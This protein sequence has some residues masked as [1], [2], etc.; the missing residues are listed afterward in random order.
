MGPRPGVGMTPRS[1]AGMRALL[2]SIV[3]AAGG[4]GRLAARQQDTIP[5]PDTARAAAQD[6]VRLPPP[7]LVPW[8]ASAL[9]GWDR[10]TWT[11]NR[12][13]LAG[14]GAFS[15]LDLLRSVPGMATLQA[16]AFVQPEAAT[17]I[18]AGAGRTEI[19]IDGYIL[20]PLTAA[21]FDLSTVE[22]AA[23]D[24][25]R[26]ERRLD[27]TRIR[28]RTLAPE[29][30][31]TFS[32][33]EAGVGEPR[34]NMFRGLLLAPRVIV[35]PFGFAVERLEAQGTGP[36]R[37]ADTFATW[38]KWGWLAPNRGL[39]LEWRSL[40]L[41]REPESA[42]PIDGRRSD[43][44]LRGRNRFAD[45]LVGEAYAGWASE[46]LE[47]LDPAVPDSLR[48]TLEESSRQAG[49]RAALQR[50][51]GGVDAALRLR[52]H[53]AFA[54]WQADVSANVA[55][56][57]RADLSLRASTSGWRNDRRTTE[58]G[59]SASLVPVDAVR[60]FGEYS[61]G[62]SGAPFFRADS[63]R[64]GP[65]VSDR[66]AWRAGVE[67]RRFGI[68]A[69][70]AAL[71][72]ETDS[73]VTFGLPGDSAAPVLP[74]GSL[75]GWEAFARVP[76]RSDWLSA[77]FAY[78]TWSSGT[79]WAYVPGSSLSAALDLHAL[80]LE[81]G[82]LELIGRFQILQRGDVAAPP[83]VPGDPLVTL[84]SRTRFSGYF[85]IRIIDVR[86]FV[87]FEDIQ[88]GYLT[89]LP[90]LDIR[91]PRLVYGVKWNFWN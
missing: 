7:L 55:P 8:P 63:L 46:R 84:A 77:S 70:A 24:Q 71:H 9:D 37:P 69:G 85:Q 18:G 91:G 45:G 11:W 4:P 1:R 20:D 66:T 56:I 88:G 44:V 82:N 30:A 41:S 34:A 72:A 68:D 47:P 65:L 14:E 22:L 35:G 73:V 3:I 62:E 57:S 26:I 31:R 12:D 39:Q 6:T 2:A 89:D 16:G 23:L 53:P 58:F 76:L 49:V 48:P 83:P 81:S 17:W 75:N 15:L 87:R 52:N 78:T 86:L 42:A 60:L 25:V 79:R 33:I 80:P 27:R 64:T 21:S 43:F 29:D 19:E 32:R 51:R 67:L 40:T 61:T 28:L 10:G 36:P 38:V 90:G 13:A 54:R 5:P 50:E 59:A 74:G